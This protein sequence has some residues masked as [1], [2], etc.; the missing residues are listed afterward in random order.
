[1]KLL[2]DQNS[3]YGFFNIKNGFPVIFY[4]WNA[5]FVQMTNDNE[6]EES[7]FRIFEYKF[8]GTNN[9]K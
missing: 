9:F 2:R 6:N 7:T 3:K 5:Y 4:G 8:A 1:M